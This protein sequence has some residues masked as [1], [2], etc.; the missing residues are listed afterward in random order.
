MGPLRAL[1]RAFKPRGRGHQGACSRQGRAAT[2]PLSEPGQARHGRPQGGRHRVRTPAAQGM[3]CVVDLGQSAHI[4][5]LIA[6]IYFLI[7]LRNRLI[8]ATQWL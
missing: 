3:D 4:Y 1:K 8:G 2:L 6:H 5:F 7:T